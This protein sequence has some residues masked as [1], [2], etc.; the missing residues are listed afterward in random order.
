MFAKGSIHW[1]VLPLILAILSFFLWIPLAVLFLLIVVFFIIFFRDPERDPE[2]GIVACA[3]GKVTKIEDSKE[4]LKIVTVMNLQNV[5]VNRAPISGRVKKIEHFDGRHI[6]AFNKD[7]EANERV[8]TTMDTE[9]G[10]VKIVQI[11]G[12]FARRIAS[13]VKSGNE[14]RKGQRIGII[15][16]GSRVDLYLPKNKV[17]L[18]VDIGA[19]VKAAKT[20]VAMEII[21]EN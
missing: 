1:I 10:E 2:K 4:H 5:H 21:D 15:R 16:F 6:P 8:I 7:S 3:D 20:T 11:A 9:I 12:A 14:V 19:K 17:R 13:Y 18:Q